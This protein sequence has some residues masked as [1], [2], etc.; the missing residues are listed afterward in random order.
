MKCFI[1]QNG[2]R[3]RSEAHDMCSTENIQLATNIGGAAPRRAARYK[4]IVACRCAHV[5][6]ID[7]YV[8]MSKC[9]KKKYAES[10]RVT[11]K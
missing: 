10:E 9:A 8:S 1:L 6:E 4:R 5:E 7:F 11:V 2:W 3:H